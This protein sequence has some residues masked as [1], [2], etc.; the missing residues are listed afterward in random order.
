MKQ[1]FIFIFLLSATVAL[2]Q[3]QKIVADRIVA[4]VG[5]KIILRSDIFNAIA[6]YKRQGQEASLPP[7]AECAFME[8]QLFK[9]HW[10]C[11]QRKIRCR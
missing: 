3:P 2:A 9:K 1:G 4:Q 6:D 8:G 5:N 7:N 10:Y 11:R